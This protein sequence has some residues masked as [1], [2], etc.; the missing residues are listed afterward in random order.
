[1]LTV[2]NMIRLT[3]AGFGANDAAIGVMTLIVEE[4]SPTLH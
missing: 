2:T 3:F 1:M 4:A